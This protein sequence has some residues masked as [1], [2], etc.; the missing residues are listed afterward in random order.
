MGSPPLVL[1]AK[2][3]TA[4]RGRQKKVGDPRGGWVGQSTKQGR[5]RIYFIFSIF[6]IVFFNSPRNAQKRDKGNRGKI[7]FGFWV[8]GRFLL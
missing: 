1:G 2:S 4:A 3:G 8:F 7:G 6:F 5:G